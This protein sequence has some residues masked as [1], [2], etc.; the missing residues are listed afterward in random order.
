MTSKFKIIDK[1]IELSHDKNWDKAKNEWY[2]EKVYIDK[3]FDTCICSHY[4]IKEIIVLRNKKNDNKTIV[5]N[6][7]I[8]LFMTKDYNKFFSALRKNKLNAMI[9]ED[10]LYKNIITDKEF[11]F[12]MNTW[13]KKK[14]TEKQT[15]WFEDLKIKIINHYKKR[16]DDT[17]TTKKL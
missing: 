1:I 2:I 15:N 3:N 5:G 17:F 11:E 14:L 7:C 12:L 4:P 8:N 13:R 9:I 16:E 6:C 10:S